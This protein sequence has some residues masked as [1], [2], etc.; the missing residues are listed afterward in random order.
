MLAA[1][2]KKIAS[3]IFEQKLK[4]KPVQ[5][6]EYSAR[7]GIEAVAREMVAAF[8]DGNAASLANALESFAEMIK[9]QD[10]YKS[11]NTITI[12]G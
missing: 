7:P 11:E 10:D 5:D 8:K 2:K 12:K 3:V 1:D 9:Q 6:L 4:E